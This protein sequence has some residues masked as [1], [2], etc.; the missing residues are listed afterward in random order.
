[1]YYGPFLDNEQKTIPTLTAYEA[2]KAQVVTMSLHLSVLPPTHTLHTLHT[3]LTHRPIPERGFATLTMMATADAGELKA[4]SLSLKS[5]V[6][7]FKTLQDH[8]GMF[9]ANLNVQDGRLIKG[10]IIILIIWYDMLCYY[11]SRCT[12]FNPDKN[13]SIFSYCPVL[14][15]CLSHSVWNTLFY[16][17]SPLIGQ[18]THAWPSAANN[19][20]AAEL[21]QCWTS[22]YV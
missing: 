20:R 4:P 14:Q 12:C 8:F 13:T 1:M 7:W 17:L 9:A 11:L 5:L 18:L 19:N 22:R 3:H 10:D 6:W 15:H 16:L 21:N 2:Q